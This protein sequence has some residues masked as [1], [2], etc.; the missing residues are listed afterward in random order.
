[1]LNR[2]QMMIINQLSILERRPDLTVGIGDE[3]EDG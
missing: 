2:L 1:M 3:Y